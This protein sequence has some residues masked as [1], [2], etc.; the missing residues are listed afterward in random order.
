LDSTYIERILTILVSEKSA[1]RDMEEGERAI[2]GEHE[3]K[4]TGKKIKAGG[5][6]MDK[7][8]E[9]EKNYLQTKKRRKFRRTK[10]CKKMEKEKKQ[11][12]KE[13]EEKRMM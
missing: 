6:I 4:E 7:K 5:Q 3:G 10:T 9:L 13:G 8:M 11:A 12:G 1:V 2:R